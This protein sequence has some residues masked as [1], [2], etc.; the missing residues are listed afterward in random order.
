MSNHRRLVGAG[1]PRLSRQPHRGGG[2]HNAERP[3][4]GRD[5]VPETG[6][7]TGAPR[8]SESV[9]ATSAGGKGV[10]CGTRSAL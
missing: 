3:P 8:R 9:T 5:A 7:S 10:V 2:G 6:P 1:D 4:R